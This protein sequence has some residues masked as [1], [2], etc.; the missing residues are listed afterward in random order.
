MDWAAEAGQELAR[1]GGLQGMSGGGQG[2]LF[3]LSSLNFQ[4]Q[5]TAAAGGAGVPGAW[6]PSGGALQVLTQ[7][8]TVPGA[9]TFGGM[10]WRRA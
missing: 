10:G 5:V 2:A 9:W 1:A 6:R 7:N 4:C 8:V 3:R